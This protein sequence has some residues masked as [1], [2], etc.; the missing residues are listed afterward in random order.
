VLR[1]SISTVQ[2]EQHP[3][4]HPHFV[5]CIPS[6]RYT[7]ELTGFGG[8]GGF[9]MARLFGRVRR[10]MVAVGLRATVADLAA[11]ETANEVF[12]ELTVTR[13]IVIVV[14]NYVACQTTIAGIFMR[15]FTHS[16]VGSLPPNG[17]PRRVRTDEYLSVRPRGSSCR[18]VDPDRQSQRPAPV[19]GGGRQHGSVSLGHAR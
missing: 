8:V 4:P 11:T 18:G 2:A 16:P 17:R 1:P 3:T 6:N 15:E 14:G 10:K 12:D 9:V 13:G 19:G 5:P 7:Y